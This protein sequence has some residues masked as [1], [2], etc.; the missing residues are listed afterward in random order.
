MA[1]SRF[2]TGECLLTSNVIWY[3]TCACECRNETQ[4]HHLA[5]VDLV[6][7]LV[8]LVHHSEGAH[9]DVLQQNN[10]HVLPATFKSYT[11]HSHSDMKTMLIL[12]NGLRL[13]L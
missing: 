1:L 2:W 3:L 7:A 11:Q 6:H 4:G 13:L 9:R 12:G 8:D 5:L 10:T